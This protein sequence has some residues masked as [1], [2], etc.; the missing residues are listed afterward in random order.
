MPVAA[1]RETVIRWPMAEG[2]GSYPVSVILSLRSEQTTLLG[3]PVDRG[4]RTTCTRAPQDL[5]RD[6]AR[7]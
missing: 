3:A 1:T 2:N 4:S 6:G 5:L 7:T